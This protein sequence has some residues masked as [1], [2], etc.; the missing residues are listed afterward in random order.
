MENWP[1]A[2]SAKTDLVDMLWLCIKQG[3]L[4]II[5]YVLK[6]FIYAYFRL[7][8]AKTNYVFTGNLVAKV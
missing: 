2:S 3:Y 6:V 1:N 8:K 4:Y 7:I 5:Y